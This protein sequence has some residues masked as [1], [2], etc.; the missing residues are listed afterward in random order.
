MVTGGSVR[1][2]GY[3]LLLELERRAKAAGKWK[4][5]SNFLR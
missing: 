3:E 4:C 5:I 1:V 2:R